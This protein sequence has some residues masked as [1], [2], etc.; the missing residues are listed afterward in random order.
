MKFTLKKVNLSLLILLEHCWNTSARSQL[1]VEGFKFQKKSSTISVAKCDFKSV[2]QE[3][4]E[5]LA[6]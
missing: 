4:A 1:I 3:V 6:G 5:F 2:N